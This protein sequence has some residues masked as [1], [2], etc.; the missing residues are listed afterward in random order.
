VPVRSQDVYGAVVLVNFVTVAYRAPFTAD[1]LH[2][3]PVVEQRQLADLE[4]LDD[5][6]SEP[7][8]SRANGRG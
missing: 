7:P 3:H 4:W 2:L 1:F 8:A 5:L 6:P